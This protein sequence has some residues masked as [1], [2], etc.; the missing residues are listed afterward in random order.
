MDIVSLMAIMVIT[1]TFCIVCFYIGAKVGQNVAIGKEIK[2]P[3]PVTA[4]ADYIAEKE[5]RSYQKEVETM[6]ENIDIYDGTEVGQK[7]V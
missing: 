4:T 5:S 6:L 3:N 1:G 7:D 2:L